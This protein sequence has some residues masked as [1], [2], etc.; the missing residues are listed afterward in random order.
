LENSAVGDLLLDDVPQI[1]DIS[2][3]QREQPRSGFRIDR[4]AE[5]R[6][7]QRGGLVERKLR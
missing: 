7:Q 5:A 4:S 6:R 2:A 1:Q 3:S